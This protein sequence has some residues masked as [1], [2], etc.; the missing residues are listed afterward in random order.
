M[1]SRQGLRA[2]RRRFNEKR[3][4]R[5]LLS[6]LRFETL[7]ERRLLSVIVSDSFNRPDAGPSSLGPADLAYGGSGTH[8]YS[9][10]F[11]TAGNPAN[12]VGAN[13]TANALQNYSN[14]YG[15]VELTAYS[16]AATNPAHLGESLGQDLD[17]QADFVVPTDSSADISEAGFFFHSRANAAGD[18]LFSG[19][20]AGFWVKVQSTGQVEVERL[21][22]GAIVAYSGAPVS[23]DTSIA[24]DLQTAVQDSQLQ[25]AIDGKLLEF[26]EDGLVSTVVTL[27]L[28]SGSDDGAA[29]I[30]FGDE[31]NPG[32]ISG[33][34]A[35]N[36][37][38][39]TYDTTVSGLPVQNNFQDRFKP[40]QSQATAANV[41]V[42]PGVHLAN[43]SIQSASEQD[44][45][46]FQL[47]Q[48]DKLDVNLGFVH[49]RPDDELALQVYDATGAPVGT[50]SST[51]N[52]SVAVLT[53]TLP[54]STVPAGTYY[55]EVSGATNTYSLSVVPDA[56]SKTTVYY[57]NDGS[58]VNDYYTTAPGNDANDGLTPATPKASVQSVLDTYTLGPTSLVVFDTGTYTTPVTI[59]GTEQGAAYAGSPGGSNFIYSGN[60]FE[61]DDSDSNEFYGLNFTGSG[62]VGFCVQPGTAANSRRNTFLDNTFNGPNIAVE[63]NGG[64]SDVIQNNV[65]TGGSYG[66][67]LPS[68]VSATIS[69][70]TISG[71]GIAIA[72]SGGAGSNVV[73]DDNKLS[74][75]N[76]CIDFGQTLGTIS[77][78]PLPAISR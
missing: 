70:N 19:T 72:A 52:E 57:V 42:G 13:L 77:T 14:G 8:Y 22:T 4:S 30:L 6:R 54:P 18:N 26:S 28:T 9:P 76:F 34:R 64:D 12:P 74:A 35:G 62:G 63:I 2:H 36:L 10:L 17:L 67:D 60:C 7:E 27:P 68:V 71:C 31:P 11:P 55:I 37:V 58:T 47:L 46:K 78:E 39:S 23:F 41:G 49:V 69:G 21:D 50:I 32:Q 38:I 45:Y 15:G 43:L 33:Q 29:G 65:I 75:T 53:S 59:T 1:A 61:L 51:A 56:A 3:A 48:P 5:G 66:I 20:N 16:D 25:V 73:V 24:H 40:D 44:W